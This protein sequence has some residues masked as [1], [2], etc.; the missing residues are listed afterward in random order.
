MALCVEEW[1]VWHN[2]RKYGLLYGIMHGSMEYIAYCT[3]V[4]V[5]VWHNACEYGMLYG[6]LHGSMGCCMA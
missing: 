6:A 1:D 4:W 2:A 5:V 3:E